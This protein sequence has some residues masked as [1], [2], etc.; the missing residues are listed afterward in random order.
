MEWSKII[1]FL[2]IL[3]IGI[4]NYRFYRFLDSYLFHF[5]WFLVLSN[6]PIYRV[7]E[8][9]ISIQSP[10]PNHSIGIRWSIPAIIDQSVT[11]L[12]TFV[13][14]LSAIGSNIDII[15]YP[16]YR[17]YPHLMIGFPMEFPIRNPIY[18]IFIIHSDFVIDW[19]IGIYDGF[20]TILMF[21][22]CSSFSPFSSLLFYA[23]AVLTV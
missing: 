4:P 14:D 10:D 3:S 2:D 6:T 7:P 17:Y 15:A 18:D 11:Q 8:S 22:L 1:D 12:S 21:F 5:Y 19:F 20:M 13:I 23:V 9:P 16:F